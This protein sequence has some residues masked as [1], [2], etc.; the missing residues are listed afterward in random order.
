MTTIDVS[1]LTTVGGTLD[2]SENGSMTTVNMSSLATVGGTLEISDNPS[3][4][5]IDVSSLTTVGGDLT[6]V[7]N[8]D[9][10]VNMSAGA[11]VGGNLTVET[12]GT[13]TFDMGD[14]A[15]GGDLSLDAT[16][17]TA[18]SGTTPGGALDLAVIHPEA[19]M[20][21]QV[22]AA[23]F[24]T[25]V[26]FTVTR[27]D[28]V[29]LVPGSGL[30]AS[31]SLATIDP[32]AAYQFNF[33]VPTLNREATLSFDVTVAQ[34]DA[35]TQTALLNALAAGTATL[36][37]KGD[38]VGSVFQ[39]FPICTSAETPTV[40]GCVR[41]ETFDALGRAT[42]GTPAIVSFSNVVGHFST[43]AVAIVANVASPPQQQI[44]G[45][46]AFFDA[47]V[48]AGTLT[49]S[50]NGNS[51]SGRRKAL[52]NMIEAAGGLIQQGRTADACQQLADALNRADGNPTPPDFVAGTATP[53]LAQR[54]RDLRAT[55]GCSN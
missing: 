46:L 9:A 49:G 36:V 47:S 5:T 40:D 8:G 55:L 39:A 24:L 6:I 51:A 11:D 32:I 26:S 15:V 53:G 48:T 28:P 20:H 44:T 45:I 38:A 31:G 13:G 14:G 37:T 27:V 54:I 43:W 4:T 18:I 30:D 33:G 7:D 29:A 10:T 23:T 25:P 1:S 2:I 19:L 50:G 22:Q 21:L 34:L 3:M 52:R 16:G 35:A 41:V 42:S 17:Y 12:T